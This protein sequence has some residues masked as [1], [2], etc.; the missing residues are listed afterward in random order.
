MFSRYY[1]DS[2]SYR[3]EYPEYKS[4]YCNP[5]KYDYTSEYYAQSESRYIPESFDPNLNHSSSQKYRSK[6]EKQSK[7]RSKKRKKRRNRSACSFTSVSSSERHSSLSSHKRNKHKVKHVDSLN[8]DEKSPQKSNLKPL[9]ERIQILCEFKYNRKCESSLSDYEMDRKIKSE[10]ISPDLSKEP[11]PER[12]RSI[13]KI[14]FKK[15]IDASDLRQA[16]NNKFLSRIP[17]T[18]SNAKNTDSLIAMDKSCSEKLNVENRQ[19]EKESQQSKPCSSNEN[20]TETTLESEKNVKLQSATEKT[21]EIATKSAKSS[22]M[23]IDDNTKNQKSDSNNKSKSMDSKKPDQR[24]WKSPGE[25]K[26]MM[27]HLQKNPQSDESDVKVSKM[28]IDSNSSGQ[29]NDNAMKIKDDVSDESA[30]RNTDKLEAESVLEKS[31]SKSLSKVSE[32]DGLDKSDKTVEIK[33]G[34]S[35][36]ETVSQGSSSVEL[37]P[38]EKSVEVSSMSSQNNEL[39]I[40][41]TDTGHQSK[42]SLDNIDS[43]KIDSS[44][45]KSYDVETTTPSESTHLISNSVELPTTSCKVDELTSNVSEENSRLPIESTAKS[46]DL[47]TSSTKH[48]KNGRNKTGSHSKTKEAE[49]LHSAEVSSTS[50][51]TTKFTKKSTAVVETISKSKS[52][53]KHSALSPLKEETLDFPRSEVNTP[54]EFKSV[55]SLIISKVDV[56]ITKERMFVT[57]YTQTEMS[58]EDD[59][60]E[61]HKK[62]LK[63][64]KKHS[65]NKS[66]KHKLPKCATVSVQT[67]IINVN[68]S[69]QTQNIRC[70]NAQVQIDLG[71]PKSSSKRSNHVQTDPVVIFENIEE[72]DDFNDK[73]KSLDKS[74]RKILKAVRRRKTIERMLDLDKEIE[75]LTKMRQNLYKILNVNSDSDSDDCSEN[76]TIKTNVDKHSKESDTSS[77]DKHCHISARSKLNSNKKDSKV[78]SNKKSSTEIE[79]NR[80]SL[81]PDLIDNHT[82]NKRSRLRKTRKEHSDKETATVVEEIS[83][84]KFKEEKGSIKEED[85]DTEVSSKDANDTKVSSARNDK[86]S[87]SKLNKQTNKIEKDVEDTS[88]SDNCVTNVSTKA[89]LK[90]LVQGTNELGETNINENSSNNKQL[91]TGKIETNTKSDKLILKIKGYTVKQNQINLENIKTEPSKDI[92]LSEESELDETVR[93]TRSRNKKHSSPSPQD[94]IMEKT[95]SRR[96]QRRKT[97]PEVKIE[98]NSTNDKNDEVASTK[99]ETSKKRRHRKAEM[100]NSNEKEKSID[101]NQHLKSKQKSDECVPSNQS[102]ENKNTLKVVLKSKSLKRKLEASKEDE[103]SSKRNKI[104][105]EL[106]D[107]DC[108]I[109]ELNKKA[110]NNEKSSTNLESDMGSKLRKRERIK[111]EN[112]SSIRKSKNSQCKVPD[113]EEKP[114][115]EDPKKTDD[116]STTE[117][118]GEY[119]FIS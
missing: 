60:D 88:S 57:T 11:S 117:H 109:N 31:H 66:D 52:R 1:H 67:N 13:E 71:N 100:G 95:E 76:H 29:S 80:T 78:K 14:N 108:T 85:F 97:E 43:E 56:S 48:S 17:C 54:V 27:E 39:K 3:N 51:T 22:I 30:L 16:L 73:S 86:S 5:Q 6:H 89:Q 84:E 79:K 69:T 65:S 19:G 72:I 12:C 99:N 58:S 28:N 2:Y 32:K 75:R 115:C 36:F 41:E 63:K 40:K 46:E 18:I 37:C 70:K 35:Q 119:L 33:N 102:T 4:D 111:E 15:K 81:T 77:K 21:S 91:N 68:V 61:S 53:G 101:E 93:S 10:P 26:F 105:T 96:R 55:D 38:L 104:P 44:V 92:Q 47:K 107:E 62:D 94:A 8:P 24:P 45:Q 9:K 25:K 110:V 118:T 90:Q 23:L 50:D 98:T 83:S 106:E 103:I 113:T 34:Q 49:I 112:K 74:H 114:S 82:S 20:I 116:V 42:S 64:D 59:K 87:D 7:K